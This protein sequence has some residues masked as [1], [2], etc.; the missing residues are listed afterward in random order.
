MYAQLFIFSDVKRFIIFI[1]F[2]FV[3]SPTRQISSFFVS[4]Y[5]WSVCVCVSIYKTIYTV[6]THT[7][8]HTQ[9]LEKMGLYLPFSVKHQWGAVVQIWFL[10]SS[11]VCNC[12]IPLLYIQH[13]VS[14]VFMQCNQCFTVLFSKRFKLPTMHLDGIFPCDCL[15]VSVVS[16]VTSLWHHQGYWPISSHGNHDE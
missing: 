13:F 10:M 15:Y 14:C 8:I 2:I 11:F 1:G 4:N 5:S 12:F 9:I 6:Y 16:P 7:Y 3:F